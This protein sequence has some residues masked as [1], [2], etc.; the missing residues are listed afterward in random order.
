MPQLP[1]ANVWRRDRH[2]GDDERDW[3][4]IRCD[5]VNSVPQLPPQGRLPL[6]QSFAD[7]GLSQGVKAFETLER[8]IDMGIAIEAQAIAC[9]AALT[10][11][12]IYLAPPT[13]R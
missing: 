1:G 6:L 3:T 2:T 9:K 12:V 4:S 8:Q 7:K 10:Q 13:V 5:V 11:V